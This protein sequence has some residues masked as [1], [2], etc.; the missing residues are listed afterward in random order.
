MKKLLL[1]VF[2]LSTTIMSAQDLIKVKGNREVTTEIS[3]IDPF[4]TLEIN[5][6][7]EIEIIPGASPQ[8][9]IT[10]DSNL[11]QF[12]T[13]SV[14]DDKLV[15]TTTAK[16]RSKKEMKFRI[17]YGPELNEITV[18][19]DA[20]LSSVTTLLFED[21]K[22]NI[23][24]DAEVY[25]TA[26]IERL[27]LNAERSTKAE[28]NLTGK[29][30]VMNL[31]NNTS[32]KALIKYD[33]LELNMKD[34]ADATIEGDIKT[35]YLQLKNKSDFKGKNLIFNKLDLNITN[36]ADA[37][38]NVKNQL[39]LES[40]GDANVELHNSPKIDLNKFAGKS[41]LSRG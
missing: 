3:P 36:N 19:D 34:R 40:S 35:G 4:E 32:V 41:V 8:I 13:A 16:I 18:T 30:A 26:K 5:G 15:V 37:V 21:L 17:I 12:L 39:I 29:K 2:A 33:D 14:I 10:T 28:L 24:K 7:Y 20:Q 1:F 11:H 27:T 31:D 22:L 9:E 25:L 6:D 23:E 38:I